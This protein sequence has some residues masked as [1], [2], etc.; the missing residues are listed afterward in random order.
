MVNANSL[1]KS[2]TLYLLL[3]GRGRGKGRT[4]PLKLK[5]KLKIRKK[6]EGGKRRDS[7]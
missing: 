4:L 5:Q 2:E 1:F 6:K 7:C 3:G